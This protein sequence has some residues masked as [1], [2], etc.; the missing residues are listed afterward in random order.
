MQQSMVYYPV[1]IKYNPLWGKISAR[2]KKGQLRNMYEKTVEKKKK[3][4][5]TSRMSDKCQVDTLTYTTPLLSLGINPIL[6]SSIL[7]EIKDIE[8][9]NTDKIKDIASFA[10]LIKYHLE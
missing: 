2:I 3:G 5:I 10:R 8:N 1:K 9:L 7:V 6:S 4:I